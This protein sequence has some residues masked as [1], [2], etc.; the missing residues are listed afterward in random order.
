MGKVI[1]IFNQKGGVA[2]TSTV[3]NLAFELCA[4][5]KRVLMVDADQQENLSISVGVIP[6]QCKRTFYDV[7]VDDIAD[8]NY[9][10]SLDDVIVKLSSG[11]HLI[12]GSIEMASMD[13]KIFS[14][15]QIDTPLEQWLKQYQKDLEVQSKVKAV[16]AVTSEDQK[17]DLKQ[18]ID[19]Y[20]KLS[21]GF[22]TVQIE[23][24][25]SLIEEGFLDEHA[26]PPSEGK[27][28]KY[29][30]KRILDRIK[31]QYDYI[32]VDCPPA[33]SAITKNI[34]NAASSV[35]VPMT[36]EPFSASGLSHLI[37][38][39]GAIKQLT[40]PDLKISGLLYTMV[41]SRLVLSQ[42]LKTQSDYFRQLVYIYDT[43]IPRSTDVN[44]AFALQ[45]PLMEYNKDNI[46][47]VAYS[48]FADEFLSREE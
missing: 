11:P 13:E 40:N 10:T 6:K 17:I 46:A 12:P 45:E 14:V 32:L 1:A 39:V 41:D 33:L 2:K 36:L 44:K 7:L 42:A 38:T 47:R 37:Q 18:E 8:I 16:P 22:R 29:I 34:L 21:A 26:L 25:K 30:I 19:R 20:I 5:G 24:I 31:D 48:A 9:D 23:L 4:R 35:I 28:G 3:N 15:L 27:D 43:Q